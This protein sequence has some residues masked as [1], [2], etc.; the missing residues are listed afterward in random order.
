MKN[1]MENR[2]IKP[3]HLPTQPASASTQAAFDMFQMR[4]S[5]NLGLA[6]EEGHKLPEA[7]TVIFKRDKLIEI[8]WTV[9]QTVADHFSGQIEHLLVLLESVQKEV[10]EALV[11]LRDPPVV[12]G[13]E[14]I[15]IAKSD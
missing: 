5:L 13:S 2:K 7:E 9:R 4:E 14:F 6:Q 10:L 11:Q 8:L 15:S 3:A 1:K 12:F